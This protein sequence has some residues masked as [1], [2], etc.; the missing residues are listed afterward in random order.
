MVLLLAHP[1]PNLLGHYLPPSKVNDLILP[2]TS[3]PPVSSP[4]DVHMAEPD[5]Q[6]LGDAENF[7][8]MDLATFLE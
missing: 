3:N 6:A 1:G 5:E 8:I 7:D 4:G 2:D